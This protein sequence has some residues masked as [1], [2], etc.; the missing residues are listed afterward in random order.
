MLA[1]ITIGYFSIFDF[2][3]GRAM[4]KFVAG[5]IGGGKTDEI[6]P[7]IWTGVT[8]MSL[9]GLIGA[10]TGALLSPWLVHHLLNVPPALQ[11][12]T[13]AAFYVLALCIPFVISS[14]GIIGVLEALQRFAAVNAVRT[15]TGIFMYLSPLMV[16]PF[17]QSL[18][19]IVAVFAA[20]R[21]L[22]WS[23]Y[24]L[25]CL[26]EIPALRRGF[27]MQQGLVRPLLA[28]GGW[29][30]INNVIDPVLLYLDRFLIGSMVSMSAVAYYA[31]PH[32]LVTKLLLFPGA[33]A[34]VFFPAFS[35]SFEADRRRVASLLVRASKAVFFVLLPVVALFWIFA[36]DGL[37]LW[38]GG[39]FAHNSALVLQ[40]LAAGVLFNG[41]AY[42]PSALVESA[43]KPEWTAKLHLIELPVYVMLLW[44][45]VGAFGI[46]GAA[47]AWLARVAVDMVVMLILVRRLLPS[48]NGIGIF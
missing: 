22:A 48:Q 31:T 14:S 41:L 42:L 24:V 13:V 44:W 39:E 26:R 38:L 4:T 7:I 29:M 16:L 36:R 47:A 8:L 9:L 35:A 15:A 18:V 40:L 20:G 12:E 37:A 45:L 3:L 46:A 21:V 23:C 11:A 30:T 33:V 32:E 43:G 28:F 27:A 1:W 19:V 34:G 17:S 25:I 10:A 2:G 5:K 6:V